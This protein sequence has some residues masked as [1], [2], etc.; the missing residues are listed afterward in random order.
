MEHVIAV[1][2]KLCNLHGEN[3]IFQIGAVLFDPV[4]H[5]T[6]SRFSEY[7][8]L[9]GLLQDWQYV[10]ETWKNK[11]SELEIILARCKRSVYT[12]SDVKLLFSVW[13]ISK[14]R[15]YPDISCIVCE[16]PDHLVCLSTMNCF[17]ACGR[18][19]RIINVSDLYLGMF[20]IMYRVSL[21]QSLLQYDP[22]RLVMA[23]LQTRFMLSPGFTYDSPD[24]ENKVLTA[25]EDSILIVHFYSFVQK[26]LK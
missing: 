5:G 21:T 2:V 20:L 26:H 16:N 10:E 22:K 12:Q 9:D 17:K 19:L 8:S 11:K 4:Q 13:V 24:M 18:M 7:G 3:S 15:Q 6:I 1:S 23:A 14:L 25:L